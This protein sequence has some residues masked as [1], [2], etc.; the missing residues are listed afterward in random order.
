MKYFLLY[1]LSFVILYPLIQ[2]IS[3]ALRDPADIHN[4]LVLWIPENFSLQNFKI[5]LIVFRLLECTKEFN[6]FKYW[7]Y[8]IT[9]TINCTCWICFCQI[10]I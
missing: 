4:A 9:S 10:E 6:Y 3:I 8:G 1:G 2:Q 5:A 7:S